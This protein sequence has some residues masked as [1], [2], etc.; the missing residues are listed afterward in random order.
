V[1]ALLQGVDGGE[2]YEAYV[3]S[4][5]RKVELDGKC[6]TVRSA[7]SILDQFVTLFTLNSALASTPSQLVQLG[8]LQSAIANKRKELNDMVFS[9]SMCSVSII[10]THY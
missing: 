8:Q 5:R 4:Y 7:I 2:S 1:R 6:S 9:I 10:C 3:L